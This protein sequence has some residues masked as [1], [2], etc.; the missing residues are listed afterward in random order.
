LKQ[1]A[2]SYFKFVHVIL[3]NKDPKDFNDSEIAAFHPAP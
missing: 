3:A 1:K 2:R